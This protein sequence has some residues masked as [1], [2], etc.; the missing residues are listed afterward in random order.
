MKRYFITVIMP[1]CNE[2]GN[3]LDAI[4]STFR[5]FDKSG[6]NGEIIVINDGSKDKTPEL[7][8]GFIATSSKK[9]SLINHN[10][11]QGVGACFWDGVLKT[12][13]E[14]ICM[15]PG[16]NETYADEIFRYLKLL[17]DVDIVVPFVYNKE[18]RTRFR[19]CFTYVCR[20]ILNLT[21]GTSF[22][23]TNGTIL[24][25]RS[26]LNSLDYRCKSPFFQADILIRLAKRGYLFAEVPY[27]LGVR[28]TGRSKIISFFPVLKVIRDYFRL[29]G[30]VYIFKKEQ[31]KRGIFIRDSVS[32]DRYTN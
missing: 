30:D 21:F 19:N 6:I 10:T 24:Y 9:V 3:I 26:I 22:N 29:V 8:N 18:V 12:E 7:V 11:S 31:L 28:N 4:E 5:A 14:I 2:E 16:D 15:I 17:E 20:T 32:Y 25:R 27:K 23:Y 1:A 13:G